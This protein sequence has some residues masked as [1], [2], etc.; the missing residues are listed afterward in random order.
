MKDLINK[1]IDLG[2]E[3]S[4]S[5]ILLKSLMIGSELGDQDFP[6]CFFHKGNAYLYVKFLP[7]YRKLRAIVWQ[8][9]KLKWA[10]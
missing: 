1:I 10:R 7:N 2:D 4:K 3:K 5:D 6:N 9:N 8:K